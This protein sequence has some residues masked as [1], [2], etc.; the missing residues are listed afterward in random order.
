[1]NPHPGKHRSCIAAAC[2]PAAFTSPNPNQNLLL[3][4][5]PTEEFEPLSTQLELVVM[6]LGKMLYSPDE[7]LQ[8]AYFPTTSIVSLH[9]ILESGASGETASV[10]SEGL[11][12]IFLF[13]GGDTTSSSAVVQTSG[14]A[15]RL[16]RRL[17]KNAFN[18]GGLLQKILLRYT[19]SLLT[20]M[21]Q[22]AVCNRYHSIEQQLCRSLLQNLDRVPT[23]DLVMT[24]ELLASLLGV[25]REG[26]TVAAGNLQ[27]DGLISYRRGHIAVL[28]REGL[29]ARCCECYE[30]VKKECTRL[31]SDVLYRQPL[32]LPMPSARR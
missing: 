29:E 22:T 31:L 20:R 15:Y 32:L 8:Y 11:V 9:Y 30:V 25:R 5:L 14:H 2:K 27:R 17:I 28:D 18:A 12:G 13:M 26:V 19:Q 1:M 21:A 7:H 4:A 24:Q 3:A 23:G 16:D 10:G 6:P